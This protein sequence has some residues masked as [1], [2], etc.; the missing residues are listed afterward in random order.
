MS[1]AAFSMLCL[2][3]IDN[4]LTLHDSLKSI[5]TSCSMNEWGGLSKQSTQEVDSKHAK[6][7]TQ[8]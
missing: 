4:L 2:I 5:L 3:S 6:I 8:W 7:E 1:V